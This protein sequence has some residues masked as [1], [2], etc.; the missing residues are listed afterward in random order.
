MCDKVVTLLDIPVLFPQPLVP[1][2]TDGG[3]DH[4]L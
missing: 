3:V 4:S 2:Q 1:P